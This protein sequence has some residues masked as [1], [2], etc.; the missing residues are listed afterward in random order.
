MPSAATEVCAAMRHMKS[1][2]M[3]RLLPSL[4]VLLWATSAQ[5]APTQAASQKPS[6]AATAGMKGAAAQKPGRKSRFPRGGMPD[7]AREYYS[8]IYGVDELS[9]Q[10]TDSGALVRFS[11]RV[12][13]DT[14]A[15]AL[16]DRSAAP[17]MLDATSRAVL[18][19]PVM[20]KIGPLRQS[21]PAK[22]GKSYWMAFSN[23]G[24]PVKS[25]HAV[26][27]QIGAVRIDG[28]TVQ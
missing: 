2:P 8:Q 20:D 25:G 22:N 13:D 6:A 27:V 18:S 17:Q 26:S 9:A 4:A 14:K 5:A 24:G 28:L 11:F 21:M 1:M 10:L 23:K 3:V 15:Q 12:V 16:Q 19:I 7:S